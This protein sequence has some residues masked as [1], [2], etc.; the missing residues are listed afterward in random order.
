M[1][2]GYVLSNKGY[3]VFCVRI[4]IAHSLLKYR[5]DKKYSKECYVPQ[6][7]LPQIFFLFT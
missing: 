4:R 3:P 1:G 6:G 5:N 2:T 7:K